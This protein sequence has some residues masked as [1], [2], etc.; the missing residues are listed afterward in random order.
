MWRFPLTGGKMTAA[1]MPSQQPTPERFFGAIN[2][3]EQTEAIKAAVELEIFTAIARATLRLRRLR[4]AAMPPS[5]G[6]ACCAIF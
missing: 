2:A 3:Y 4:G 5:A 1:A 6:C